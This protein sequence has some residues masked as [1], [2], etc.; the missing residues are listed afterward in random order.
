V[1]RIGFLGHHHYADAPYA[2][3]LLRAR[4]ERPR[5]CAAEQRDERAPFHSLMPPVPDRKD[6]T[7][8]LL[9]ETTRDFGPAY[10]GFGSS[11]T[12]TVEATPQCMSASR[13]KRPSPSKK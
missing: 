9:Q 13:G 6:S 7:A 12:E 5:G 1:F 2:L 4:R 11:A 10:D 3:A 8:Q